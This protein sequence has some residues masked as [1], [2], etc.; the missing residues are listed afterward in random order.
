MAKDYKKKI[1]D[2]RLEAGKLM[3]EDQITKC[4]IAIHAAAVAAGG[5]GFIPIPVADAI[6][7]SAAQVTMVG[8]LEIG[9]AHV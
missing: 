1:A 7:I 9:R 5:A 3:T 2:M 4:N 8:A 6:P